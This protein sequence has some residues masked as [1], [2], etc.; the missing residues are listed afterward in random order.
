MRF[1]MRETHMY[2]LVL[3]TP[4]NMYAYVLQ[5]VSVNFNLNTLLYFNFSILGS[6]SDLMKVKFQST[7]FKVLMFQPIMFCCPFSSQAV[8]MLVTAAT[9][10]QKDIVE[11]GRV[12]WI[13]CSFST[14]L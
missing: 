5:W 12:K 3:Y 1:I 14:S 7:S 13:L 6:C 8:H 4:V 2:T 10:L 9:D 11:G